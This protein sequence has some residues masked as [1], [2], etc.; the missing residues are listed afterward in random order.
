MIQKSKG[1]KQ[2][3]TQHFGMKTA[4]KFTKRKDRQA[5]R[6][7]LAHEEYDEIPSKERMRSEDSWA[8]D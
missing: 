7:A 4:K 2:E 1:A 6:E 5:V 8:W 3:D